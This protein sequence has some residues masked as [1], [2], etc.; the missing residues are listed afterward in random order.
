MRKKWNPVIVFI[1]NSHKISIKIKVLTLFCKKPQQ[2]EDT[3][4]VTSGWLVNASL[5]KYFCQGY[6]LPK[7]L[8]RLPKRA[9]I[10]SNYSLSKEGA[11]TDTNRRISYQYNCILGAFLGT[12]VA[13]LLFRFVRIIYIKVSR[14]LRGCRERSEEPSEGEKHLTA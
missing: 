10:R 13:W 8:P 6:T 4:Q 5:S 1:K 11:T 3:V 14:K 7:R 2:N 9:Y 12:S